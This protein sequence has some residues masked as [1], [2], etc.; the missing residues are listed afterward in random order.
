[1]TI[2]LDDYELLPP[3]TVLVLNELVDEIV[4]EGRKIKL[5]DVIIDAGTMYEYG[6]T[7]DPREEVKI[8]KAGLLL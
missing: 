5:P 1:M 3:E 7:L 4:V 8:P 2:V 6:I